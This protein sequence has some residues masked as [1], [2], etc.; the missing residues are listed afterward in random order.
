M[1]M[2]T[3]AGAGIVIFCALKLAQGICCVYVQQ[4]KWHTTDA[5]CQFHIG[6]KSILGFN[7]WFNVWQALFGLPE[8]LFRRL[9]CGAVQSGGCQ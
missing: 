3:Q 9:L 4:W 5:Q 8:R 2:G 6:M 1:K 7:C